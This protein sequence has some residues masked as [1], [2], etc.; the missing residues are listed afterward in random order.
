MKI[1]EIIKVTC[2]LGIKKTLVI[3]KILVTKYWQLNKDAYARGWRI[4]RKL[5]SDFST[6]SF[7][8]NQNCFT[9]QNKD[10]FQPKYNLISVFRICFRF[11]VAF[12]FFSFLLARSLISRLMYLLK[13]WK[14]NN[15]LFSRNVN[16]AYVHNKM[17]RHMILWTIFKLRKYCASF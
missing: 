6:E 9:D 10:C 3:S 2:M 4:S 11:L 13:Y 16:N 15:E 1:S 12:F 14:S 8:I 5:S 17:R 7:V